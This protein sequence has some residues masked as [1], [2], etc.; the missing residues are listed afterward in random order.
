MTNIWRSKEI[1]TTPT[2]ETVL[3]FGQNQAGWPE[4]FNREPEGTAI[5]LQV[6]EILQD[7]N[8]YRGNLR[9]ARAAFNSTSLVG[10]TVGAS[11]FTYY[12]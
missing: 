4:F 1:I 10:R 6:G 3:D 5:T 9:E 11:T 8:F 7:S 2:G 12:G